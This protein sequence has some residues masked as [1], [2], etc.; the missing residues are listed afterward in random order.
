MA[1]KKL[2]LIY[3]GI[4]LLIIIL[5]NGCI[6]GCSLGRKGHI[7]MFVEWKDAFEVIGTY[8]YE[9]YEAGIWPHT[10]KLSFDELLSPSDRELTKALWE[11]GIPPEVT[12]AVNS[13]PYEF[14]VIHVYRDLIYVQ[15]YSCSS[16][17]YLRYFGEGE[18]NTDS[19]PHRDFKLF[20]IMDDWYLT[21][22]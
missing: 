13:V 7:E 19:I 9:Q 15:D 18:A 10:A 12:E 4:I 21:L 16:H 5:L 11:A 1:G 20:Y 17:R 8:C 14:F 22:P 2:Y 3:L 6:G